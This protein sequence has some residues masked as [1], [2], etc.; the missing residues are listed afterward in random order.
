MSKSKTNISNLPWFQKLEPLQ[1][2]LI[3]TALILLKREQAESADKLPDYSFLVFPMAKAY[4]GFIKD[5]L[6]K[7]NLITNK[8]YG[9]KRFRVGKSV[10]PDVNPKYRGD[11]W[12]YNDLVQICGPDLARQIWETWLECRNRIFHFF[13]GKNIIL[14]LEA[15]EKKVDM[16]LDTIQATS[17]YL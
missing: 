17:Q 1:R 16:I 2:Q 12:V 15:A 7:S 5:F 9:S 10:N 6:L 13:P 14:S 11:D 4:E 3:E 8:V